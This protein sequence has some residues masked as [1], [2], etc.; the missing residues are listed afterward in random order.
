MDNL[1][2]T[3][4]FLVILCAQGEYALSQYNKLLTLY[5]TQ[6]LFIMTCVHHIN[7]QF[8]LAIAGE[9]QAVPTYCGHIPG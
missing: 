2:S 9:L 5:A 7:M 6:R 4:I 1:V 8:M 3:C